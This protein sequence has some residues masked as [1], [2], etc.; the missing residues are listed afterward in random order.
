MTMYMLTYPIFTHHFTTKI[1]ASPRILST[2]GWVMRPSQSCRYPYSRDRKSPKWT[3]L[4]D[5]PPA[6]FNSYNLAYSF[7]HS[8]ANI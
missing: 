7:T 2:R 8:T 1:T 4:L 3:T 6:T 5:D